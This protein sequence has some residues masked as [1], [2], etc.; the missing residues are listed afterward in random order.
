MI[1][2]FEK[3][4]LYRT[5]EWFAWFPVI[6]TFSDRKV[7]V[8]LSFVQRRMIKSSPIKNTYEYKW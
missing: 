1:Y 5:H 8:W 3:H 4:E 7:L 6:A 2:D